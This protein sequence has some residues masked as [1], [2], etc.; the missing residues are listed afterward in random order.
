MDKVALKDAL[1]ARGFFKDEL[2]ATARVLSK[3]VKVEGEFCTS[4]NKVI[5]AKDSIEVLEEKKYVSRGGLKL[6]HAIL[7]FGVPIEGKKCLDIGASSGGFTDCLLQFGAES[8]TCVDVNYGQLDWKIRKDPKTFIFERT[9][10]K[11]VSCEE[12]GGPFDVVVIDVSFIG[13]A[14]L[15]KKIASFCNVDGKVSHLIALVKPQFEA[16]KAEVKDGFVED[17]EVKDRTVEEVKSALREVGFKIEGDIKSPI[18][19][20]KMKNEEFLIYACTR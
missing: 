10:I 9:N 7:E 11:K 14:S 8:V 20:K 15:A 5:G 19:G 4:P 1:V 6:E 16:N 3:E 12:I 2:E 17:K 13:L 18:V